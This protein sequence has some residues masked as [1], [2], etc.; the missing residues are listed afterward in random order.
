MENRGF[1]AR[2]ANKSGSAHFRAWN[3]CPDKVLEVPTVLTAAWCPQ[4]KP[5]RFVHG[6]PRGVFAVGEETHLCPPLTVTA[7]PDVQ[8]VTCDHG[9]WCPT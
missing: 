6:S 4:N 3:V 5:R 1:A 2:I 7:L 9:L 8:D